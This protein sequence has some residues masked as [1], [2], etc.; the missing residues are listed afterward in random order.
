MTFVTRECYCIPN[1]SKRVIKYAHSCT[2][3]RIQAWPFLTIKGYISF[4]LFI[5]NCQR[6]WWNELC[7]QFHKSVSQGDNQVSF[8]IQ[9]KTHHYSCVHTFDYRYC[10]CVM[11][12]IIIINIKRDPK[13]V[14]ETFNRVFHH[15]ASNLIWSIKRLK[16]SRLEFL[17]LSTVCIFC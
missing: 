15:N 9:D 13:Y 5:F 16:L 11:N 12:V 14:W 3:I 17:E 1:P 6:S 7:L 2:V 8:Y 10:C 4:C